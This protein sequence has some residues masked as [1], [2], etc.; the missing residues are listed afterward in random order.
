MQ[1]SLVFFCVVLAVQGLGS[2]TARVPLIGV[3]L[4]CALV[5]I[6]MLA[7]LFVLLRRIRCPNGKRGLTRIIDK[8]VACPKCHTSLDAPYPGR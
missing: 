6:A 2:S 4:W 1:T 3:V 5:T 7:G 8:A